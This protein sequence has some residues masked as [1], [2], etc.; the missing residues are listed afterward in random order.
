MVDSLEQLLDLERL[1][2]ITGDVNICLDKKP[3]NLITTSLHDLG[4]QQLV[5]S[6]THV[7]GGRIDHAYLR[8]P[9]DHQTSCHLNQYSPYYSDHNGLCLSLSTK[10]DT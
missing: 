4:F 9:E 3:N 6:P 8:K 2:L 1:T 7:A 5:T 10:V